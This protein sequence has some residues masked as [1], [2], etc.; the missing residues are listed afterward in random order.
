[1]ADRT[2][3]PG[4]LSDAEAAR[5]LSS[6]VVR[7]PEMRWTRRLVAQRLE[8]AAQAIERYVSKP[9]PSGRVGFW[10][11]IVRNWR[12][13]TDGMTTAEIAAFQRQH[14][15]VPHVMSERELKD[16]EEA[17]SWVGRYL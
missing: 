16:S 9:G 1:M 17:I 13:V 2:N 8:Q 15:R 11:E 6:L 7:A 3:T 10:P 12:E 4:R 14:N 5:L